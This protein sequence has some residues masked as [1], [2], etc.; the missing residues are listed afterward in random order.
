M[1]LSAV[2]GAEPITTVVDAGCEMI[3]GERLMFGLIETPDPS[4]DPEGKHR[5]H[6]LCETL[7]FSC[8]YRDAGQMAS[9]AKSQQIGLFCF[10]SDLVARVLAVGADVIGLAIGDRVINNNCIDE[11]GDDAPDRGIATTRA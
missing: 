5:Q 11:L 10:G 3:A 2:Y 1:A 4:F 7:A 6:V 9:K 8:N